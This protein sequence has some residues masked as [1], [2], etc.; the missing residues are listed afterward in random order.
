[1]DNASVVEFGIHGLHD[2]DD[3]ERA[4]LDCFR[5]LKVR[6]LPDAQKIR[7]NNMSI[8][9]RLIYIFLVG[10]V[11]GTLPFFGIIYLDYAGFLIT[12]IS[13]YVAGFGFFLSFMIMALSF[14]GAIIVMIKS[15]VDKKVKP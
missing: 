1:M 14:C 15:L 12:T 5:D 3:L 6:A 7:S 8:R 9:Q 13:Q 10:L 4:L 2:Q 11:C